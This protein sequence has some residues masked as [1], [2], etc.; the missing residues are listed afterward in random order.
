MQ[1]LGGLSAAMELELRDCR[2][3]HSLNLRRKLR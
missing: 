1:C 2:Y 3:E